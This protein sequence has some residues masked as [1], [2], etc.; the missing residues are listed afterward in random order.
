VLIIE[1]Y[2]EGE[3]PDMTVTLTTC[4]TF[5]TGPQNRLDKHPQNP[6][7]AINGCETDRDAVDDVVAQRRLLH[8]E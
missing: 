1:N 3:S 6:W 7:E 5:N 4:T 2:T 8:S